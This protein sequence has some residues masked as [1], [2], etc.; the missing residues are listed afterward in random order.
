MMAEPGVTERP[1]PPGGG[2]QN[3]SRGGAGQEG[4]KCVECWHISYCPR[5]YSFMS[6]IEKIKDLLSPSSENSVSPRF[7]VPEMFENSLPAPM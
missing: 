4:P 6:P 7:F 5:S 3:G 2:G 1:G